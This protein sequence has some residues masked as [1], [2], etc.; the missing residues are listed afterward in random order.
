MEVLTLS[1]FFLLVCSLIA[2]TCVSGRRV[3][4]SG[5]RGDGTEGQL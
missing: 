5:G 4:T 3:Q 2:I 1:Q